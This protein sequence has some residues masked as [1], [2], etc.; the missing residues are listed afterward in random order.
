M[1]DG[2]TL[3]KSIRA[4]ESAIEK[5]DEIAKG[6]GSQ[7]QALEAL[8]SAYALYARAEASPGHKASIQAVAVYTSR[9]CELYAEAIKAIE[10]AKEAERLLAGR[11][12]QAAQAALESLAQE[13]DAALVRAAEAEAA[14][15]GLEEKCAALEAQLS[16]ANEM[17][18][19]ASIAEELKSALS[20]AQNAK[21]NKQ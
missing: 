8:L 21:G 13:R 10:D 2:K 19:L 12:A 16:E 6:F 4:S 18:A 20:M 9:I 15:K 3:P 1:A 7:G 5:F 17:A 14:A 11:Q